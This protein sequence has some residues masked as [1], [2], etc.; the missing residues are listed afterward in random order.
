MVAMEWSYERA[1]EWQI[2][3]GKQKVSTSVSVPSAH[4]NDQRWSAPCVG[5]LKINVDA[6]LGREDSS[7]SVGMSYVLG[8]HMCIF[9][10]RKMIRVVGKRFSS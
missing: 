7:F 9:L 2:A 8:N 6:Q 4:V 5:K 1:A 10:G 3:K